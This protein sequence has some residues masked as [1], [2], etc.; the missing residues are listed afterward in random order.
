MASRSHDED[1]ASDPDDFG[2]QR[3]V[4]L[5]TSTQQKRL[6]EGLKKI[7][8]DGATGKVGL[9]EAQ[10]A[11]SRK[12]KEGTGNEQRPVALSPP[13]PMADTFRC[14]TAPFGVDESGKSCVVYVGRFPY[15]FF[16]SQMRAYFA[17]FGTV[18]RLRVSRNKTTGKSKHYAF[19]EFEHPEVAEIVAETHNNMLMCDRMIKCNVVPPEKVSSVVPFAPLDT[20]A[21]THTDLY[22]V[23]QNPPSSSSFCILPL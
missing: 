15:G 10:S 2:S 23:E 19:I 3:L 12:R 7:K 11:K 16:E 9:K 13:N 8:A 4:V 14:F 5:L 20:H 22:L 18:R 6:D 1:D 21:H 17:L